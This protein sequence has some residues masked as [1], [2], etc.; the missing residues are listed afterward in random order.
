MNFGIFYKY[1]LSLE[2]NFFRNVIY[3]RNNE[4]LLYV[5]FIK[6]G[7]KLCKVIVFI[8]WFLF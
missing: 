2:Y 1:Y 5:K 3:K 8:V 6:N 7:I 4:D